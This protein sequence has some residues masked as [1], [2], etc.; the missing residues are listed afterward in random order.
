M[1]NWAKKVLAGEPLYVVSTISMLIKSGAIE[2]RMGLKFNTYKSSAPIF[3]YLALYEGEKRLIVRPDELRKIPEDISSQIN[4]IDCRPKKEQKQK[5]ISPLLPLPKKTINPKQTTLS[6]KIVLTDDSIMPRCKSV[7]IIIGDKKYRVI[8]Y[9]SEASGSLLIPASVFV[10]NVPVDSWEKLKLFDPKRLLPPQGQ[11]GSSYEIGEGDLQD[12]SI[13]Y[14][15]GYSVKKS[16]P[17]DTRRKALKAALADH[18]VTKEQVIRH[19]N[20]L[21]AL[22]KNRYPDACTRWRDD[23]E[24]LNQLPDSDS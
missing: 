22:N 2:K 14:K 11:E 1:E 6:G 5:P 21:I 18:A 17:Y 12:C 10:K 20:R 23:I 13:L 16:V 24:Y 15:Y 19:N 4:V 9:R 3:C 7:S 8:G